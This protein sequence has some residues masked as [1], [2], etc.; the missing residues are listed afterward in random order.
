MNVREFVRETLSQV[1]GGIQDSRG[2][3][4]AHGAMIHPTGDVYNGDSGLDIDRNSV[5]KPIAVSFDVAVT[6]S[7]ST[8]AEGKGGLSVVGIGVAGQ[9][10]SQQSNQTVSRIA[11]SVDIVPPQVTRTTS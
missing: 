8:S 11:F 5:V 10:S 1:I 4:R 9:L 6:V 7:D 3:M 2:D